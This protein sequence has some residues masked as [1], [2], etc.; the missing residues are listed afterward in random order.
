MERGCNCKEESEIERGDQNAIDGR[1]YLAIV[2]ILKVKI[3]R[4]SWN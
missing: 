2:A 4:I 1:L 3:Y